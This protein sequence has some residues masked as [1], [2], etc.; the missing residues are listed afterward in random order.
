M[1][2]IIKQKLSKRVNNS[3]IINTIHFNKKVIYKIKK[4]KAFLEIESLKKKNKAYLSIKNLRIT[5]LN[6]KL[7][8]K[9]KELFLIIEKLRL[10]IKKL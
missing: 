3:I 4:I 9:K 7:N 2:I 1:L 10:L 6:K 5:R 8:Y